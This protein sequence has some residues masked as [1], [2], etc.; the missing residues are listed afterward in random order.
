MLKKIRFKTS[1]TGVKLTTY[2]PKNI[3][4][5]GSDGEFYRVEIYI[6]EPVQSGKEKIAKKAG[7]EY[8]FEK[9]EITFIKTKEIELE[10]LAPLDA[11]RALTKVRYTDDYIPP[12]NN[13]VFTVRYCAFNIEEEKKEIKNRQSGY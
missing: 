3:K 4:F 6:T 13:G 7:K 8:D 12:E 2:Q 11:R 5:K 1:Q 9:K 10:L